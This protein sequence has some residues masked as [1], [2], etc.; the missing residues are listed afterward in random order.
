[1]L[2]GCS[3]VTVIVDDGGQDAARAA[4]ELLRGFDDYVLPL[5]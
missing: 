1:M 5:A 4:I 3:A 2:K